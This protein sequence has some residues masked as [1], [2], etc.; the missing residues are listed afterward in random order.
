MLYIV[1]A[2]HNRYKT[3]YQFVTQLLEQTYSDFCLVLVDDGSTDASYEMLCDIAKEDERFVILQHGKNKSLATA[4]YTAMEKVQGDYVLF[5]DSD[6]YIERDMYENMLGLAS[7]TDADIVCCG[8][9]IVSRGEK[10]GQQH[11]FA[12]IRLFSPKEAFAEIL[13]GG[14]MDESCCD[15]IFRS[16]LF[17]GKE[18]PEGAEYRV[19]VTPLNCWAQKGAPIAT[20]WT[21]V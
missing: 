9:S 5:L 8:R 2:V 11:C 12:G 17:A 7:E 1:T 21:R 14:Q 15:K 18:F 19:S 3:T 16:R 13:L 6:D 4:R 20:D 10:T